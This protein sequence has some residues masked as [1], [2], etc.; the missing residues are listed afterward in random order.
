MTLTRRIH[1]TGLCA[2]GLNSNH[3]TPT[4]VNH[5]MR[6]AQLAW[7]PGVLGRQG[8]SS[9]C[10][11]GFLV[12]SHIGVVCPGAPV[13]GGQVVNDDLWDES[14]S[15]ARHCGEVRAIL[16]RP[17]YHVTMLKERYRNLRT[18]SLP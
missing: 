16:D 8:D 6:R 12:V 5:K 11:S 10:S 1:T 3:W 7:L 13:H 9:V 17:C 15:S 4:Q 2:I 18:L 14:K